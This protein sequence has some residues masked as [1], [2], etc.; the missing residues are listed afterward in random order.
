MSDADLS[1]KFLGQAAI[2]YRASAAK[3]CS[4]RLGG[5]A[6]QRRSAALFGTGSTNPDRM[7]GW[8]LSGGCV[9]I[10]CRCHRWQKEEGEK[11]GGR[12]V[13]NREMI[14]VE[15]SRRGLR[16]RG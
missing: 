10:S 6:S 3:R 2:G 4:Q 15:R 13:P 8:T 5:F 1:E 12:L 16:H 9:G 14:E 7:L 11:P